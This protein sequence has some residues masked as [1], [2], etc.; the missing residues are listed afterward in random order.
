MVYPQDNRE[1]I[2]NIDRLG[3]LYTKNNI[4]VPGIKDIIDDRI[5]IQEDLGDIPVQKQFSKSGNE[6]KKNILRKTADILKYLAGI[7][8]GNTQNVLGQKRLKWEMDFFLL[9]FA[10]HIPPGFFDPANLREGLFAMVDQI[11]SITCFA[12]RDFHSRNMMFY[13]G[14]LYLIDFQDS[15]VASPYYDLVSFAFDSYLDLGSLRKFFLKEYEKRLHPIDMEQ[16]HL[17]ALQRNIKA[18]GTFGYQVHVKKN[19]AYKKYI[20]RTLRHIKD[21]PA[22]QGLIKEFFERYPNN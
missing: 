14:E 11:A 3:K 20:G 10:G 6:E 4:F 9:H 13:K 19:L 15:L 1:E 17:A 18:L 8:A 5:I 2:R 16:L 12:H 7:A 22:A 21:N